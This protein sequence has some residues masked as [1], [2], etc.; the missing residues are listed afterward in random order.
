MARQPHTC[1]AYSPASL[2]KP[3]LT[4]GPVPKEVDCG[5]APGCPSVVLFPHDSPSRKY[6]PIVGCSETPHLILSVQ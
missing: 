1:S 4:C 5:T 6:V 2:T 3:D